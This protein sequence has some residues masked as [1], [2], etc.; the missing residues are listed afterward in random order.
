MRIEA[1][2]IYRNELPVRG[3]EYRTA[4]STVSSLDTTIVEV[5]A[6]TGVKGYGEVCPIGPVYQPQHALGARSALEEMAPHLIGLDP[7]QIDCV[8]AQMDGALNG[9]AYAKAAV[10][11]ALW[12][13]AG[14]TYGVRVCDLLGGGRRASVPSYYAIGVTDPDTAAEQAREKQA[15]GF[16]RLQL[17]VG[18]RE[19]EADLAAIRKVHE[20]LRPGV[21]LAVDANR[22]WTVRDALC[23]SIECRDL[24]FIMEQPCSTLEEIASIRGRTHQPIFID[25][26]AEGLL[27]VL[28]AAGHGLCDGFGLKITRMGGLSPMRTIRDVCKACRLPFTCDD[29]WGGDIIAAACVHIAATVPSPLLEGVWIAASYINGHYDRV[30]GIEI[31]EGA[32]RVPQGPGLGI[33]PE[34]GIWGDPVLSFG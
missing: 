14:K 5:V 29:S 10:D 21:K 30:N 4:S 2:H 9:H 31:E 19:L 17:K 18:G 22:G 6:D 34:P 7:L 12:D 1:I 16:R 8:Y 23:V 20:V 25:E 15:Q 26:A 28:R 24:P 27:V 3:G 13:M 32:I 11:I 33:T